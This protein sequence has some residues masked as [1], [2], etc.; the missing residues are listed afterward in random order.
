MLKMI[1]KIRFSWHGE[2]F[3]VAIEVISHYINRD[4]FSYSL[5]RRPPFLMFFSAASSFRLRPKP[6]REGGPPSHNIRRPIASHRLSVKKVWGRWGHFV[7][8]RTSWLTGWDPDP[9][10]PSS[11]KQSSYQT[12]TMRGRKPFASGVALVVSAPLTSRP[13]CLPCREKRC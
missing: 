11:L 1:R 9:G 6:K 10:F 3:L 8:P 7:S 12:R 2:S 5:G 13:I 4:R